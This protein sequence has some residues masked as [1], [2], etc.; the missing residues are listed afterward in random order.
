MP[1]TRLRKWNYNSVRLDKHLSFSRL[2]QEHCDDEATDQELTDSGLTAVHTYIPKYDSSIPYKIEYWFKK[3][4][5]N[6]RRKKLHK[7]FECYNL[8]ELVLPMEARGVSRTS[9]NI[10]QP[11][12]IVVKLSIL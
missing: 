3:I 7:T 10:F 9:Q 11:L 6:L 12:T 8:L 4:E 5:R 1:P 2:R